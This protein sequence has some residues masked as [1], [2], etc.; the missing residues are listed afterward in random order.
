MIGFF[1]LVMTLAFGILV[2]V[3]GLRWLGA[4]RPERLTG[5][6]SP[7]QLE[8]IETAL[9]ALESR[10]ASLEEQQRFL[11][12]LVERRPEPKSLSPGNDEPDS[13][14]FD[15]SSADADNPEGGR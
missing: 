10:L 11:E 14:L 1:V 4:D 13:I 7:A 9:A 2:V 3:S 6:P 5:A 15:R 8:R 12:R